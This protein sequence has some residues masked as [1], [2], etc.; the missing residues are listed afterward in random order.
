MQ[1]YEHR[2]EEAELLREFRSEFDIDGDERLGLNEVAR[3]LSPTFPTHFI[4]EAFDI[5]LAADT[6]GDHDL[7]LVG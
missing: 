7:S 1:A 5:G 3:L 2:A 4:I 6:T